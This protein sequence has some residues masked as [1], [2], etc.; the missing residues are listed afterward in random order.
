MKPCH[1]SICPGKGIGCEVRGTVNSQLVDE[2]LLAFLST[3]AVLNGVTRRVGSLEVDGHL[4]TEA[5]VSIVNH[6]RV[7]TREGR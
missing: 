1:S 2:E 6:Q 5:S 4:L 3:S 7:N